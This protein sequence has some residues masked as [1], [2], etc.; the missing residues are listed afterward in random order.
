C[1]V[2]VAAADILESHPCKVRKGGPPAR[3]RDSEDQSVAKGGA[4]AAACSVAVAAADVLESHPCKVRKGGPPALAKCARVGHP[5]SCR[6]CRRI[7]SHPCKVRKGGPP[8]LSANSEHDLRH[9]L[10]L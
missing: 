8:A 4:E 6:C 3:G 10:M 7:G 9:H 2:A 5:R 1:S